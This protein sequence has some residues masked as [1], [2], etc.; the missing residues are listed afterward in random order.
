MK[1]NTI[2][3]VRIPK[4]NWIQFRPQQRRQAHKAALATRKIGRT[5][6]CVTAVV[7]AKYVDVST[8]PRRP[9]R[10]RPT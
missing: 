3:L 10:F 6:N 8:A 4:L 5:R 9:N 2:D 1:Q 7:R